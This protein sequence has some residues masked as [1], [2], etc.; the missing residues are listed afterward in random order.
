MLSFAESLA[1]DDQQYVSKFLNKLQILLVYMH[2][3]FTTS[4]G[5]GFPLLPLRCLWSLLAKFWLHHRPQQVKLFNGANL[6]R[7]Y[8]WHRFQSLSCFIDKVGPIKIILIIFNSNAYSFTFMHANTICRPW[9]IYLS[10]W[11]KEQERKMG[12]LSAQLKIDICLLLTWD[13][14]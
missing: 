2:R 14:A 13:G 7:S 1:V 10:K 8:I 6:N 4:C 12:S 3:P 11:I 9:H 5:N